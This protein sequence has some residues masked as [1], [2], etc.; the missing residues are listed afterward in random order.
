M[1]SEVTCNMAGIGSVWRGY[2]TSLRLLYVFIEVMEKGHN[3]FED[4][5]V[6][7]VVFRRADE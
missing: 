7:D 6:S 5:I 2:K 4:T 3:I 1:Y